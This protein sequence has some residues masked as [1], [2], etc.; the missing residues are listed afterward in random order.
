MNI[1]S[2]SVYLIVSLLV[3]L[4]S[5]TAVFKALS[6]EPSRY[7]G[8]MVRKIEF[9]GLKNVDV[10]DVKEIMQTTEGYPLKAVEVREDIKNIFALGPVLKM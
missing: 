1:K 8:K 7:E 6:S 10:E 5:I 2:K 4:I 9:E 3:F